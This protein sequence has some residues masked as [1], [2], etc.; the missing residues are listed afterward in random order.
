MKK[1]S[2]NFP[3]PMDGTCNFRDLGGYPANGG[4]IKKDVFIDQMH[5]IDYQ[6]MICLGW[7]KRRSHMF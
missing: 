3:V 1:W 4:T 6:R 5:Y 2:V 7:K